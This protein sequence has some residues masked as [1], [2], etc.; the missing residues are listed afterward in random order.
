MWIDLQRLRFAWNFRLPSNCSMDKQS[1][2]SWLLFS[3]TTILI[4]F[5]S[6]FQDCQFHSWLMIKPAGTCLVDVR[7]LISSSSSSIT[8]Q[9]PLKLSTRHDS[10]RSIDRSSNDTRSKTFIRPPVRDTLPHYCT[11]HHLLLVPLI[12][13]ETESPLNPVVQS[14]RPRT[15]KNHHFL[16][17]TLR[18]S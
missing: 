16:S 14:S 3:P 18:T 7:A 8:S 13:E 15:P 2:Q 17:P 12:A 11:K 9:L 10:N 5:Q 1:S 4:F 6:H